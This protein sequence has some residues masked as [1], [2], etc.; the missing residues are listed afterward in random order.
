MT[1][2][3]N[4]THSPDLIT[5][6][7]YFTEQRS[8]K[9]NAQKGDANLFSPFMQELQTT[10][11]DF[12]SRSERIKN[13]CLNQL[14]MFA[15]KKFFGCSPL[16]TVAQ[17][18]PAAGS[19]EIGQKIVTLL[20]IHE[21]TNLL[22][23]L[24]AF[25]ALN[26]SGLGL[27]SLSVLVSQLSGFWMSFDAPST[28]LRH[29]EYALKQGCFVDKKDTQTLHRLFPE[30]YPD[31]NAPY[32][33]KSLAEETLL[34]INEQRWMWP[35]V[36]D[37][38]LTPVMSTAYKNSLGVNLHLVPSFIPGNYKLPPQW[39]EQNPP[40][41]PWID[42]NAKPHPWENSAYQTGS[43]PSHSLSPTSDIG[44]LS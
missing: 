26:F 8:Q 32:I 17:E 27:G 41:H 37:P 42:K 25:I 12:F 13:D 33:P 11:L 35:L 18:Y 2:L 22:D 31:P 1:P 29:D 16:F 14:G 10:I 15:P 20:Q 7:N 40:K 6:L 21:K 30:K 44:S 24:A 5:R 39:M 34:K 19:K 23:S 9:E 36:M 43:L 38:A 3:S 4:Y 28:F